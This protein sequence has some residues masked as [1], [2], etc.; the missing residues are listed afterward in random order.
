MCGAVGFVYLP[1]SA[2]H[3]RTPLACAMPDAGCRCRTLF[4]PGHCWSPKVQGRSRESAVWPAFPAP[5]GGSTRFPAGASGG[6]GGE[7]RTRAEPSKAGSK[8]PADEAAHK[9]SSSGG[10]SNAVG[11]HRLGAHPKRVA[12]RIAPRIVPTPSAFRTASH[13]A[14][15]H[16]K[17]ARS[18]VRIGPTAAADTP[19]VEALLPHPDAAAPSTALHPPTPPGRSVS[20]G[21]PSL[22]RVGGYTQSAA[23]GAC[24]SVSRCPALSHA[25][26]RVQ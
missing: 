19:A 7:Q 22:P 17:P 1:D 24:P 13:P 20:R 4:V 12:P 14:H 23:P 11:G 16:A 9:S 10:G 8:K 25:S 3:R 18:A 26:R 21:V 15:R 5:G 2:D 6:S